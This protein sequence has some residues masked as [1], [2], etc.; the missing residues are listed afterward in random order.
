MAANRIVNQPPGQGDTF[1]GLTAPTNE[2]FTGFSMEYF[3]TPSNPTLWFDDLGFRTEVVV[4]EPAALVLAAVAGTA[5]FGLAGLR[6]R[7]K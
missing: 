2:Y 5:L 7:R 4:P 1:F 3:G 6:R